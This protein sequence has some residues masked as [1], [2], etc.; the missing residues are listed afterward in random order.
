[1]CLVMQNADNH[2]ELTWGR[3]WF[4]PFS[5]SLSSHVGSGR[6]PTYIPAGDAAAR[7]MARRLGG[8]AASAATDIFLDR[9]VTAHILGGCAIGG[10]PAHGVVD[11]ECRVFGY[12][13]LRI[14]DGS[15]IPANLGV[16]PS[17]SITAIAEYAMSQVPPKATAVRR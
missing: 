2:L 16:N 15:M 13:S 10:D 3:R 4:W 14:V 1:M 7:G 9:P 12:E 11:K 6:L 17:L 8:I 5:R